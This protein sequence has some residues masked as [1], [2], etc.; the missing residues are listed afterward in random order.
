MRDNEGLPHADRHKQAALGQSR[1]L[2]RGGLTD[3]G[4]AIMG[5]LSPI[6]AVLI[7]KTDSAMM[8][9]SPKQL[10]QCPQDTVGLLV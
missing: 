10:V 5:R 3:A 2:L 8:V 7:A 1:H 9:T 4:R 6:S